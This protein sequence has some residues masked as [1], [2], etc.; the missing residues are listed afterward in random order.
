[1]LWDRLNSSQSR[2]ETQELSFRQWSVCI[3]RVA[4]RRSITISLKP[5]QPIKVKAGMGTSIDRIQKFLLQKEKWIEKNLLKFA[6]HAEKFPEKKLKQAEI[7]PFLGEDLTLRFVPTPL[8]QTFF[9]RHSQFLQM[10]LPETIWKTW[11]EEEIQKYF[12]KLQ[13]FYRRE[14]EKLI[15]ERIQVWAAQMQLFPKILKFR[16]QKTR[17]GSCSSRGSIQINWRLVAAPLAVIDYILVHELAHLQHMNHSKSFWQLVEKHFP[18]FASS[19]K[20]LKENHALL[21]FLLL[22]K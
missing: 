3:E 11:K 5:G 9:S 7:F 10:H 2:I 14:A 20:W 17:W 12:P 19:E 15:S 18:D 6:E 22:L 1:M 8:K 16:N 4:F 13:E 21:D